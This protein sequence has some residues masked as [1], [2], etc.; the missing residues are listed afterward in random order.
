MRVITHLG[1]Y[2]ETCQSPLPSSYPLFLFDALVNL[3]CNKVVLPSI[4]SILKL[5]EAE[6]FLEV[7]YCF[8]ETC[9]Y[10]VQKVGQYVVLIFMTYNTVDLSIWIIQRSTINYAVFLWTNFLKLLYNN[11]ILDLLVVLI[12]MNLPIVNHQSDTITDSCGLFSD[13]ITRAEFIFLF[14][15]I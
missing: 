4:L 8:Q 12:L 3:L 15:H 14:T 13:I 2:A 9:L 10:V 11:Y 6:F 5:F 1:R 7:I